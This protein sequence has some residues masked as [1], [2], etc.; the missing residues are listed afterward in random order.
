MSVEIKEVNNIKYYIKNPNDVIQNCLY[1][2]V[3]WNNEIIEVINEL[4][5]KY[6]LTHLVNVGAHI[7]SVAIP[8]SKHIEKITAIEAYYPTF[9][10]LN[11]NIELNSIEN[12][13]AL[14]IAVG[15]KKET[16]HFLRNDIDRIKNNTGGMHVI[17]EMDKKYNMRSSEL[18]D[19]TFS[20]EMFPL[21]KVD[22]IDNFDIILVDIEGMD[23]RFL[24][25]AKNKILKNKPIIIIEIWS[26]SKRKE[27]KMLVSREGV[28]NHII[29]LGYNLHKQIDDD[30][31]F[32]P[33]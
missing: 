22:E 5:I 8:L 32:L 4:I 14:N 23:A 9:V 26:N 30:F 29:E 20:C 10:D 3:Q 17:T 11:N 27:E 2:G 24:Q 12:I 15:D 6:D 7:G 25:G 28:I 13:K 19:N 33:K 21:D 16:I 31:I 1:N 18:V